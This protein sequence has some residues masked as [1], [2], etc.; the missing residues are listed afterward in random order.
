MR[1]N[2]QIKYGEGSA[3]AYANISVDRIKGSSYVVVLTMFILFCFC[4]GVVGAAEPEYRVLYMGGGTMQEQTRPSVCPGYPRFPGNNFYNFVFTKP[5]LGDWMFPE[6]YQTTS[7]SFSCVY[8]SYRNGV[9]Y[10]ENDERNNGLVKCGT[11]IPPLWV[12][13]K[14]EERCV[15]AYGKKLTTTGDCVD[16]C[17]DGQIPI[18][19]VCHAAKNNGL[20]CGNLVSNPI[21]IGG[22]NKYQIQQVWN[23]VWGL[24]LRLTYNSQDSMSGYFGRHW[25][26]N[27]DQ[28]INESDDGTVNVIRSDG[29]MLS[30]IQSGSA[31]TS[32]PDIQDKL[33]EIKDGAGV[34][35]G[36]EYRVASSNEVETYNVDG[37]LQSV[38]RLDGYELTLSY[39]SGEYSENG[40]DFYVEED[41]TPTEAILEK[42]LL[43]KVS[44][45]Y[46]RKV[47]FNYG[48]SG[49][50]AIATDVSG[51]DHKFTYDSTWRRLDSIVFP[52]STETT[53]GFHYEE[54]DA[55]YI[56]TGITDEN[57]NRYATWSYDEEGR[58]ISSEHAN[59]VEK[60]TLTYNAD[61]TTTATNPLG[62]QT[63]YHFTTIHG[64]RK[65][66]LVEGHPT[67]SCE[68][69]NKSYSYDANG[70][71]ASK[72]DWN[73]V[74]TTYTYDM[75]RNL[76]LTRT[77]AQGTPQERTITTE[78]H[79]QFRLPTK[80][81]EP[82]KIT[83]YTYDAQGRQ[84]SSKVSSVQ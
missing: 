42:G 61:G 74:T 71:I 15:C 55:P 11:N 65:V 4:A 34:R 63:T 21:N 1:N 6:R 7:A 58:A 57:G 76:E 2:N 62:K 22:G 59:G 60:T 72:T 5:R 68:G 66:T 47:E 43:L 64:V 80:I 78:W 16:E 50:I 49:N 67:A 28:T 77:E 46:G 37:L 53:V 26:S 36:W 30:F 29:R 75:D 44:D 35:E 31:W 8:T 10:R 83:E 54:S 41:G 69:A 45:T 84:L 70:N 23:D 40:S 56:L 82:G 79:P 25:R 17:P 81:T 38:S 3:Y 48:S 20:V 12:V 18:D 9:L 52:T 32:D 19:G 33:I 51:K 14:D 73:G 39:S 24:G 13:D 27:W